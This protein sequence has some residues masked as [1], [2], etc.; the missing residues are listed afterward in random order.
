M[1][2]LYVLLFLITVAS[3]AAALTGRE[4]LDTAQQ[5]NGFATWHDRKTTA[6]METYAKDTLERVRD[7]DIFE[8]PAKIDGEPAP[9]K[10]AFP[11]VCCWSTLHQDGRW[12]GHSDWSWLSKTAFSLP[13]PVVWSIWL[14]IV[15]SLP[16]VSLLRSSRLYASTSSVFPR[17]CC[18]TVCSWSSGKVK[19]TEIGCNWV[20]TNNGFASVACTIL[21]CRSGAT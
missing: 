14:S 20:M 1:P 3:P 11:C 9:G 13:V 19:I 7:V 6:T 16:V 18:A 17:I 12:F 2:S 10:T 8:Q 21:P 15:T 5:K 4:V